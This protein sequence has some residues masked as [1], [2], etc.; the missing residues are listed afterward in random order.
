MQISRKEIYDGIALTV[1]ETDKFKFNRIFIDFVLPLENERAAKNA[2]F[3]DV[4][5]RGTEKYQGLL[6]LQ[7][8]LSSLYGA[9]VDTYV[10][11]SGEAHVITVFAKLLKDKYALGG[12]EITREGAELL[13]EVLTN[14]QKENGI[15]CEAY[16][17]SEKEKLI[18][19]IAAQINDKDAYALHRAIEIMCEG[20]AW[21]ISELGKPE[22]VEKITAGELY[23]HYNYVLSH[24]QAEVF[25]IGEFPEGTPE[26][27]V[28]DIFGGVSR[29]EVPDHSTKIVRAAGEVKKAVEHQELRQG[30]LVLGFRTGVGEGEDGYDALKVF[31]CVFGS[32]TQSKLFM[33]VREK[34]SLC[35]HCSSRIYAKGVMMVTSGIEPAN[36]DKAR[37]EILAQLDE[38]RN[39]NISDEEM[40]SAKKRLRNSML[41]VGDS[42]EAL[43]SWYANNNIFSL[44]ATPEEMIERLERVTKEDVAEAA[45]KITLDTE[46]FLCGKEAK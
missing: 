20:E 42:P 24:A 38:I 41:S 44:S 30:K 15:F 43:H 40:D 1:I 12:E 7:K 16:V 3:A 29:G 36:Y 21:G 10:G 27:L 39:G 6:P 22:D 34:L 45:K 13:C 26:K 37:N 33:N 11:T 32:G 5:M 31:N 19:D 8:K 46:Y 9:D 2:L 23:D 17:E 4:L 14:P 25:A 18:D 28:R 35:Y